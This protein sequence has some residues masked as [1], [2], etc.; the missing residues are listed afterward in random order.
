MQLFIS[1]GKEFMRVVQK[2]K[3]GRWIGFDGGI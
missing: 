2:T 1:L 3:A